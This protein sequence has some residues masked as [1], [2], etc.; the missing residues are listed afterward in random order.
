MAAES[1]A[2]VLCERIDALADALRAV[3]VSPE[4]SARLLSSAAAATMAAVTLDALLEEAPPAVAPLEPI[5]AVEP[6]EAPIQLAA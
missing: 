5:A 4:R 2:V 3:G 1:T 6:V